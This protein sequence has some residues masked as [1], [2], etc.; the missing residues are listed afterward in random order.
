MERRTLPGGV[1]ALVPGDLEEAGFV[2]L[3]SERSGGVS[4]GAFE[5][6]NLGLRCGDDPELAKQNRARLCAAA[7]VAD[8]ACGRQV[9]GTR[10]E[11]IDRDRSGSGYLDP[12][13]AMVATDG[14]LTDE[15]GVAL[16]VLTAD[17][18]PVVLADPGSGRLVVVHAGWRG[19]AAGIVSEALRAFDRPTDVRAAIGPA[20]GPDHYEVGDDVAL[21]VGAACPSGAVTRS[22]GGRLLLDLPSSIAGILGDGGVD[23]ISRTDSCTS[24]EEDRFFSYR[25][26]GATGRQGL[27]A[28]RVRS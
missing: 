11:R 14:L 18:V 9:H 7:G 5:S 2:A 20:I 12:V 27:V 15:Q 17:C 25:R 13:D 1:T 19:I 10:I 28:V 22:D 4:T 16:A 6:L 24:C 8:F 26:D 21:A 3:F 23:S